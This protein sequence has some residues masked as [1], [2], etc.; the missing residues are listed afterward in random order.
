MSFHLYL[1]SVCLCVCVCEVKILWVFCLFYW[2]K[3]NYVTNHWN[4]FSFVF[5]V[6]SFF[7]LFF[8]GGTGVWIQGFT[9]ARQV[10]FMLST[11][12]IG[13]CELFPW[14]NLELWSSWPQPPEYW[15]Y[16]CLLP[17][18]A[19]GLFFFFQVHLWSSLFKIGSELVK[20]SSEWHG[21]QF[22]Y[23]SLQYFKEYFS[24]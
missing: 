20:I 12:K 24:T 7:F 6:S 14:A 17:P 3:T 10:L 15:D 21:H 16:G 4:S 23:T 9:L 18:S 13:S 19:V 1:L 8:F 5:K 22:A 2:N 11:L